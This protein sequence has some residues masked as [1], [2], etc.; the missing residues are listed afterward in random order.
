MQ[1]NINPLIPRHAR[2]FFI[3]GAVGRLDCLELKPSKTIIGVAIICHPDPKGGGTYTNKI[4]QTIAR[5]L[6]QSGYICYCPNLRGV[7]NSDGIHDFGIGEVDDA[8]AVYNFVHQHYSN[9]P[10]VLAGFSFGTSIVSQ[11]ASNVVH[12]KLLLVGPAVTKYIVKVPDVNKTIVIHGELDEI[13]P[14]AQVIEWAREYGL[15]IIC[16]PDTGHFFHG[17]L[18]NL[19]NLLAGFLW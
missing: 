17:K 9:L 13:I 7:G 10:L 2:Q 14:F 12:K 4:V 3:E 6:N 8:A 1:T 15:P 16:Y 11:L 5:V 18:L 19:Q